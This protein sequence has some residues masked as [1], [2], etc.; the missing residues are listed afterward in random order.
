VVDNGMGIDRL[1][2][3][4]SEKLSLGRYIMQ[5]CIVAVG[6]EGGTDMLRQLFELR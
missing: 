2:D 6:K 3:G 5:G 1:M 4:V